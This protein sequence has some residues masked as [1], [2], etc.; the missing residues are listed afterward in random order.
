VLCGAG[1]PN[2]DG[3]DLSAFNETLDLDDLRKTTEVLALM[4]AESIQ[5]RNKP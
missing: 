1:P 4:I 5:A 2:P 3:A